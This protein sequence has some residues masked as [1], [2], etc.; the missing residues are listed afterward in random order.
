[1]RHA[2]HDPIVKKD[3]ARFRVSRGAWALSAIARVVGAVW[4]D[5]P[6]SSVGSSRFEMKFVN[7]FGDEE[8]FL[9]IP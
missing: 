6:A 7:F 5:M 9:G 3:D 2:V 1:V 4:S 8:L